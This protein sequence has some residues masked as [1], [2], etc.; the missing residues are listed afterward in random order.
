M[1]SSRTKLL[2]SVKYFAAPAVAGAWKGTSYDKLLD[3][4]ICITDD[5]LGDS[6]IFTAQSMATRPSI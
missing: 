3:G 1:N 6:H 5:G 4:N 2:E